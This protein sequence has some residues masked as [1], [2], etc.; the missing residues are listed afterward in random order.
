MQ[1]PQN[2]N[3]EL[4]LSA[5]NA[6]GRDAFAYV[7]D[8]YYNDLLYFALRLYQGTPVEPAD[9]VHDAFLGL[10]QSPSKCF[11]RL[12][13]IKAYLFVALN[14]NCKRYFSRRKHDEKYLLSQPGE[15]DAFE[16][17]VI[18]SEMLSMLY[19][20]MGVLNEE[21]AAI[22]H[23]FLQGWDA[24]EIAAKLGK[25]TRTIYNRKSEAVATLRNKLPKDLLSLLLVFLP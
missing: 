2:D 13:G 7:Y 19:E 1:A 6:R 5:F 11:D 3:T 12:A 20:M 24:D 14:N 10:W 23:L 22:M 9:A 4:W 17:M 16:A 21:S 18:E 25:T 15:A 8:L